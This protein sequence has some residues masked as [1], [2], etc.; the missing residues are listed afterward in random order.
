MHTHSPCS[1]TTCLTRTLLVLSVASRSTRRILR[2]CVQ[3]CECASVC[4]SVRECGC[5]SG[6]REATVVASRSRS[7]SLSLSVRDREN[8]VS[9]LSTWLGQPTISS[10]GSMKSSSS[11]PA[12]LISRLRSLLKVDNSFFL[13]HLLLNQFSAGGAFFH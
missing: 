11:S 12:R 2:C 1:H 8:L 9:S 6:V 10:F 13:S 3:V 7:L 5:E 4:E